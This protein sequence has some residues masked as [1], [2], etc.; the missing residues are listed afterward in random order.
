M[1]CNKKNKENKN[2]DYVDKEK[3]IN[4]INLKINKLDKLWGKWKDKE[5][6]CLN[7]LLCKKCNKKEL[8][9]NIDK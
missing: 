3:E 8:L 5:W 1:L 6:E 9:A 4:L 2:K 7:K